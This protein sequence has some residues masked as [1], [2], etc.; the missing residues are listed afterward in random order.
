MKIEAN[1]LDFTALNEM[2]KSSDGDCEI[3]GCLGQRFIADCLGNGKVI[4]DGIPGN[5]LGAHLNGA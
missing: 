3:V 1:G 5:A 4:I 2:I